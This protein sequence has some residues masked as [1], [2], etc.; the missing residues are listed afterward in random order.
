M[1]DGH[2]IQSIKAGKLMHHHP[3]DTQSR[4][5]FL[6]ATAAALALGGCSRTNM[7]SDFHPT[8]AQRALRKVGRSD[9]ALIRCESYEEDLFD[10]L[11][12]YIS[13]MQLP[14]LKGKTVIVKP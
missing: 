1:C 11:R 8:S 6:K 5:A 7:F 10:Q 13:Q 2:G 12:P 3:P 9:V 14:D 4:R